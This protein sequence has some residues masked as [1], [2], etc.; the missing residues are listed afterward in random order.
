MYHHVVRLEEGSAAPP[1]LW[2]SEPVGRSAQLN[3]AA[4]SVRWSGITAQCASGKPQVG[5]LNSQ[6]RTNERKIAERARKGF[7]GGEAWLDMPSSE[8]HAREKEQFARE[9]SCRM[10]TQ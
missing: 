10:G 1:Y 8:A 5:A 2:P 4:L 7:V 9:D 6:T 3:D